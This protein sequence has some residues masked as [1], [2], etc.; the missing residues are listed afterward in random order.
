MWWLPLGY[1]IA[2]APVVSAQPNECAD[3]LWDHYEHVIPIVTQALKSAGYHVAPEPGMDRPYIGGQSSVPIPYRQPKPVTTKPE[4]PVAVAAQS[5]TEAIASVEPH[6]TPTPTRKRGAKKAPT[7]D[8]RG[9]ELPKSSVAR[10][11]KPTTRTAKR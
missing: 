8:Q 9:R 5:V 11:T 4:K 6:E 7:H 3:A 10:K 2:I 1:G